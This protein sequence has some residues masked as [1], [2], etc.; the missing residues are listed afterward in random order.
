MRL[1]A[2]L[3]ASKMTP[4]HSRT[5]QTCSASVGAGLDMTRRVGWGKSGYGEKR[6]EAD[7]SGRMKSCAEG[8]GL[9]LS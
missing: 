3:K 8:A 4:R 9:L 7:V 1:S 5:A 6:L 2:P